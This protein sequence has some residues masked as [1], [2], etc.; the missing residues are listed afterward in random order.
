[1]RT[2]ALTAALAATALLAACNGDT[3]AA[4]PEP[5]PD[6]TQAPTGTPSPTPMPTGSPSPE[7]GADEQPTPDE[8]QAEDAE[9]APVELSVEVVAAGL[10]VPWEV[11]FAG[12]GRAFV[13]ER[14]SGA[15]LELHGDGSTT[16]VAE[17]DVDAAGEGGLLGLA[18]DPHAAGVRL[19]AYLTAAQDNRVVRFAP[20]EE[21]QVILEGIP[22]A[23]IHNGGRIAFGPDGMLYIATGDAGEPALSQDE[24]SLAGKILRV[25]PEGG[26]PP[27]NPFGNEVWSLGHRNVQG[28]AWTDEGVLYAAEL[29]PDVDDEIN[30]IEAGG[31]Y[32]WPEVTGEAGRDPYID[33]VFVRQPAE[34]SWS[35]MAL[36]RDGAI[37]Q[38]EGHAFVAALRGERV[39]RLFLTADGAV[40]EAEELLRGEIGRVRQIAQAPDGSLWIL[41][42]NRDG[43]G[44]PTL[45]DDRILRI[46]PSRG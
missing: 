9:A 45:D 12:D 35:G 18:V 44:S 23:R 2:R 5:S 16:P 22:K 10:E 1:M 39:W 30:R 46:G 37:P 29:G 13:S 8:A 6:Q 33:P 19:Y 15:V 24:A 28:L 34:A 14:D 7:P 3:G 42:S 40:A 11:A 25:E 26:V 36:L 41:T 21:P 4:S 20:G 32:G 38:W 27:D 43:R 31:N 17:L